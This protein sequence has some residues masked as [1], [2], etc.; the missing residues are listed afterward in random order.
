VDFGGVA[1]AL[2]AMVGFVDQ[3]PA[4]SGQSYVETLE[5]ALARLPTQDYE[6]ATIYVG[7][8]GSEEEA[9]QLAELVRRKRGLPTEIVRGGQP[10]YAYLISAE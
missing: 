8:D 6:L 7:A 5:G 10:H 4:A 3:Q 2:G 1:V 9:N